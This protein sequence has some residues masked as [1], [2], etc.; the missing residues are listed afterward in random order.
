MSCPLLDKR[1]DVTDRSTD[2][3]VT[4]L[5][6]DSGDL[7]VIEGLMPDH[8]QQLSI[9][10]A[11]PQVCSAGY[12]SELARVFENFLGQVVHRQNVRTDAI[13]YHEEDVGLRREVHVESC[14]PKVSFS[15]D[16]RDRRSRIT[17][18]GEDT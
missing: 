13:G 6:P 15:R 4:D 10:N 16:V 7:R 17:K 2:R 18:L 12:S 5:V 14:T 9:V 1:P 3:S 8:G 11:R